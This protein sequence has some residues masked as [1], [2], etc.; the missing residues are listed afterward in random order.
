MAVSP[1]SPNFMYLSGLES[2]VVVEGKEF[3][4][5]ALPLLIVC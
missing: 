1:W 3:V 5:V 4:L 2:E